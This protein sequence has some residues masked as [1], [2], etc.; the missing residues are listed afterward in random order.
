MIYAA[1]NLFEMLLHSVLRAPLDFL[2]RNPVGRILNR[3]S[4]DIA[5]IDTQLGSFCGGA[6][7]GA[8]EFIAIFVAGTAASWWVL[9]ISVIMLLLCAHSTYHFYVAA[10]NLKHLDSISRSPVFERFGSIVDGLPTIRAHGLVDSYRQDFGAKV[11]DNTRALWNLWLINCWFGYR[12]ALIGAAF[13]TVTTFAIISVPGA[14]VAI[15]GFALSFLIRYTLVTSSFIRNYINLELALN[16]VDRVLEYAEI[17]SEA[18]DGQAVPAAWPQEG[19]LDV[20]HLVVRHSPHL[21][22]VLD[23]IS[24]QILPSQRVGVVGRTGAGKSS[25][26]MALFRFLEA[27]EGS[28]I[29]DGIDISTVPLHELRHR[30]AV[31]PQDPHLFSGTVRSNLDPFE[32]HTDLELFDALD[33]VHWTPAVAREGNRPDSSS[34]TSQSGSSHS[35][36]ARSNGGLYKKCVSPLDEEIVDAGRNLSL[37]QRQQLCLARAIASRPKILVMDE[38]TSSI[39][40]RTDNLIQESIREAF[41]RDFTTLLVIAHRISTVIDFDRILV[42][43]EGRLVEFGSPQE[44]I[45]REGG[46]FRALFEEYG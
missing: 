10:R 31:I 39:D 25:L 11:D 17:P 43:D 13:V 38:A 26:A 5:M 14:T 18:Y 35:T 34:S 8:L 42:L 16:N 21:P 23:H 3:F 9:P 19:R 30:L 20:S 44:L 40:Q 2:D 24:F 33:R 36:L 4:A 7:T 27:E 28:I 32:V 46:H 12:M 22:P 1:R 41:G 6:L 15:T 37:G 45:Q 29:L